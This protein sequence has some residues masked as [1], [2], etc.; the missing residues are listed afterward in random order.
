MKILAIHSDYIN[1]E[2]KKKAIQ[3]AEEF[4]D[5]KI[6]VK[7]CLVVFTAVEKPDEENPKKAAE[8]LA[9]QA[10]DISEQV[11]TKTIVLYP[12]AHLS[13]N[14]SSPSMG[15]KVMQD[16]AEIL[17]KKKFDVTRAPFGWYKGFDIKCKGH[18]LSELSRE[19]SPVEKGDK[20]D[21]KSGE[22]VSESLKQETKIKKTLYVLENDKLI[23]AKDYDF[24]KYPEL[25]IAY[26][27]E[28]SGLRTGNKQP[29]HIE[30][31]KKLELV[32]YEPGSDSGHFRWYPKGTLIKKLLE[33]YVTSM[34]KKHGAMQVET[35]IMYDFNHPAL[36][37]YL[38]RFPA[39]QYTVLS[40]NKK[41]FLRFSACFGQYLIK[42]DMQI[43]Y[44]NLPLKIY[45]LTHYAFR[46]EQTGELSG[47]K[48]LR[49]FTMPDMHTL[50][51]DMSQVEKE[52][53]EQ[54]ILCM[55]YVDSLDM[56]YDILIRSEENFYKEHKKFISSLQKLL[57]KPIIIELFDKRYAYFV[58][59]H[60]LSVND[61]N[62]KASTL[63]T[64][65]I[66]VENSERF[67][68]N[69]INE[70]GQ[71]A[72][73]LML[74]S[75]ISGGIDRVLQAILE[76]QS[77]NQKK[78]IAPKFPL[79]LSPTQVRII[80]VSLDKHMKFSEKLADELE[81]EDIRVDID[82]EQS[83]VGKKI[84]NAEKDWASYVIVVGD[85]ELKVKQLNI[86]VRG[87]KDQVKMSLKNLI[88]EI[89]EK[90]KGMPFEPIAV[91]R[92][93]SKQPIFVG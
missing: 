82:D 61:A 76:R 70:K 40:D 44:K 33:R 63:S 22:I 91:N 39:R 18:P 47:I 64:V 71:K 73:P 92:Y 46:R 74:H 12:Y 41:F 84:M 87:K 50:C 53:T 21:Q 32:D 89:K 29:P 23:L 17:K 34:L 20:K 55:D 36:S 24:K 51:A 85:N 90:T 66:D 38:H 19:F 52:F 65:Q 6:S 80:P 31:M 35:P 58:M 5:D 79:W 56:E 86:R 10:I 88:K 48:R 2:K 59:K 69:Y 8:M 67:G 72:T 75:S 25:K 49:G 13:S 68:I 42:H 45:E 3:S 27:Y 11:K 37:K 43:S 77:V 62:G 54:F 81:K 7:E 15:M 78:G 4:K 93:L 1:I 28:N 26:D 30:L 9:D 57:K 60:E 83:T 14:L 16:A